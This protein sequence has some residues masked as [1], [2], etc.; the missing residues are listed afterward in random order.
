M[1]LK[2]LNLLYWVTITA[3]IAQTIF[4]WSEVA[5]MRNYALTTLRWI[6]VTSVIAVC[7]S[8]AIGTRKHGWKQALLG[9]SVVA[10]CL[11]AV[12]FIHLQVAPPMQ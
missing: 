8:I 12:P 10:I 4:M 5:G 2:F 3:L 7:V 9:F 1:A 6:W 11:S